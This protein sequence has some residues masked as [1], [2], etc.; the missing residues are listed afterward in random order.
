MSASLRR[1]V[2][3]PA[4]VVALLVG[5]AAM[6]APRALALEPHITPG[7]GVYEEK[8][9]D[10]VIAHVHEGYDRYYGWYSEV[11]VHNQGNRWSDGFHVQFG[12]T[13]KPMAGLGAGS[14][15]AVYFYRRSCDV[16][17]TMLVDAFGDVIELNEGNNSREWSVGCLIPS[18]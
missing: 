3:L 4:L 10:L 16:S 2:V 7:G 17:G 11:T 8:G 18:R 9:P 12:D 6:S 14:S 1:F 5:V 13:Y 15:R